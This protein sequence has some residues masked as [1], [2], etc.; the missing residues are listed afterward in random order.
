[1]ILSEEV[2]QKLKNEFSS[3]KDDVKLVLFSKNDDL[4]KK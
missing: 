3:L 1:M 2:K 4:S